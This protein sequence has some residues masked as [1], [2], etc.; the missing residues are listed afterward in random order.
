MEGEKTM[1]EMKLVLQDGEKTE[2]QNEI[3]KNSE[4]KTTETTL[5]EIN[6]KL[7]ILLARVGGGEI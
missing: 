6:G 5:E 4:K 7:D 3:A 2:K 1:E